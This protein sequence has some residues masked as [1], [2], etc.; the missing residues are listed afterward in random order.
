MS[1]NRHW[2]GEQKTVSTKVV[3][4]LSRS[5]LRLVAIA[6][7]SLCLA[8][9]G[10]TES[11]RYKLTLAVNT[12][13]GVK[14]GSSVVEVVF[15]DVSI[16]ARGTMHKLRGEALYLDLGSS[17]RP[18]I[19]L[20]T[21]Q[22]HPKY[23]PE[24]RWTRDA[25][26]GA[27]QMSRLYGQAPSEDFMDDVPRI[28]RMLGPHRIAPT[29]LPDLVTFADV[30]DPKSVIEV[31]PNDLQATLGPNVTWNEITLES[32]DEPITTGIVRKLPWLPAYFEKNL[33]GSDHGAKRELANILSWFDFDQSGDLK[34]KN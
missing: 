32:T 30:N 10:K 9:C 12:P 33:D 21:S 3:S 2:P 18:L 13:A 15:W 31:N 28:A 6:A 22:L 19:A 26:P 14:R 25:G 8:G 5:L 16:P 7:I 4:M 11:Y 27:R 24:Q 23:G 17:A 1:R 20:L 34:R 29:E